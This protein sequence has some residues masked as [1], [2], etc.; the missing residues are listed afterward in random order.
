MHSDEVSELPEGAV[1]LAQTNRTA[2]QAAEIRHGNGVFWGVQY[3]PELSLR[4]VAAALKRGTDELV[5]EGLATGAGAVAE[6]AGRIEALGREPERR[7]LAWMLGLDEE[8]TDPARRTREISNFIAHF[9]K[10]A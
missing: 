7:D 10:A 9:A 1:L 2:V 6:H 5:S 3:H 4:E 8:V